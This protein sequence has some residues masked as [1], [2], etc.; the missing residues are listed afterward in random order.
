M[1]NAR[2]GTKVPHI[3]ELKLKVAKLK[4]KLFVV[5]KAEAD[6]PIQISLQKTQARFSKLRGMNGAKDLGLGKFLLLIDA[7][8]N[9][10]TLYIPISIA[11][12]RKSTG[13]IYQ[14]EGTSGA[15]GI[16]D[17]SF[18]GKDA[19]TVTSGSISYCKIP[20][21]KTATFKILAEVTGKLGKSYKIVISRINYKLNPNDLRYKRYLTEIST[22]S[23]KFK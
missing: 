18:Q 23:L 21:G 12:G 9:K 11:S 16:A 10:E 5:K 22:E 1:K 15:T 19:T 20:I 2:T 14:I 6:L 4:T 13:F 8:A 7:Q 3:N 17:I